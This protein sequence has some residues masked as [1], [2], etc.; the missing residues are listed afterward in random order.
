MLEVNGCG[1][2]F[3]AADH[4]ATG[5]VAD[6]HVIVMVTQNR[7]RLANAW[8]RLGNQRHVLACMQG[9]GHARALAERLRPKP[10]THYYDLAPH[11]ALRCDDP[12]YP[13]VHDLEVFDLCILEDPHAAFASAFAQGGERVSRSHP[14]VTR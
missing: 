7:H 14:A 10:G 2:R 5:F 12:G 8:E 13:A 6:V 9:S 3:K 4:E 11:T 1:L